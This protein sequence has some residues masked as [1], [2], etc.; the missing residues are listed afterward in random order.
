MTF[1]LSRSPPPAPPTTCL[2]FPSKF[3]W[4]PMSESFQS[5]QRSPLLGSQLRTDP[6][7]INNYRSLMRFALIMQHANMAYRVQRAY[8][9]SITW[10]LSRGWYRWFQK[11][12]S[13]S[14]IWV[15]KSLVRKYLPYN[16]FVC[17]GKTFYHQRFGGKKILRK[18]IKSPIRWSKSNGRPLITCRKPCYRLILRLRHQSL[19]VHSRSKLVHV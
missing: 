6:Q 5:F 4:S 3:E 2:H 1:T 8:K 14:L 9:G 15:Q 11:K 17:Q 7:G 10:L 19:I 12:I 16:S 18:P 13:W